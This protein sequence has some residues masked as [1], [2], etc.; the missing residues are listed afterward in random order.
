MIPAGHLPVHPS[1]RSSA[2]YQV[3]LTEMPVFDAILLA[4]TSDT[5][6]LLNYWT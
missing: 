6:K 1:S 2:T 3:L 5:N 4:K